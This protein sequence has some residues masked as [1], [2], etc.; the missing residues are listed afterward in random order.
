MTSLKFALCAVF[1]QIEKAVKI[2]TPNWNKGFRE[3]WVSVSQF[4]PQSEKRNE[5]PVWSSVQVRFLLWSRPGWSVSGVVIAHYIL[6]LLALSHP[7]ASASQR[8][9]RLRVGE[10]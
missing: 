9:V 10:M 8:Q 6:K 7:P 2:L 4:F 3:G 1:I 5:F